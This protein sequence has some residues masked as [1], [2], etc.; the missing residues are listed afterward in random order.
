[1]QLPAG[2]MEKSRLSYIVAAICA[3]IAVI[4]LAWFML[5][6]PTPKELWT[7]GAGAFLVLALVGLLVGLKFRMDER[8]AEEQEA[9][10]KKKRKSL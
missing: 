7:Y 8:D 6:H 3:V 10:S 4:L 1:M 5:A 2:N 9:Q